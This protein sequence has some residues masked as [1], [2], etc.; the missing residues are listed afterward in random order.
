MLIGGRVFIERRVETQKV[1]AIFAKKSK[2]SS[3]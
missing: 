3:K 1:L 2:S